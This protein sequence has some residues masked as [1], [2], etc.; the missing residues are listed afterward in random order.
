ML[1]ACRRAVVVPGSSTL[2]PSP[3]DGT[4]IARSHR[5]SPHAAG[6][7]PQKP[8]PSRPATAH[9]AS[10]SPPG[11][12]ARQLAS[13]TCFSPVLR[14]T[15]VCSFTQMIDFPARHTLSVSRPSTSCQ[16]AGLR[17]QSSTAL[18]QLYSW[19][20]GTANLAGQARGRLPQ[21]RPP[22]SGGKFLPAVLQSSC[23]EGG[24][25]LR[26]LEHPPACAKQP[27]GC[28]RLLCC[29]GGGCRAARRMVETFRL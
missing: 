26:S 16:N 25:N 1:G 13:Q 3:A 22:S 19:G 5:A 20:V 17:S 29:R 14:A 15:A 11:Q 9:G 23:W 2:L 6:H 7:G 21:G 4:H 24:T 8:R 27:R 18:L 12:Q 10:L 28:S